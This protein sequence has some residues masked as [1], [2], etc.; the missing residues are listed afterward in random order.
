MQI[1]I[2]VGYLKIALLDKIPPCGSLT[3]LKNLVPWFLMFF[4]SE[5]VMNDA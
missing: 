4:N 5:F 2:S 1:D 3:L